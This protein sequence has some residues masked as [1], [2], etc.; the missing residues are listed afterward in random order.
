MQPAALHAVLLEEED[1]EVNLNQQ[2]LNSLI[3]IHNFEH[4]FFLFHLN[5]NKNKI[6]SLCNLAQNKMFPHRKTPYSQS[7]GI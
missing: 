3:F 1:E 7:A 6:I 4:L 5:N 2:W